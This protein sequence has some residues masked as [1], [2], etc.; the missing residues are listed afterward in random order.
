M[1]QMHGTYITHSPGTMTSVNNDIASSAKRRAI[2][3]KPKSHTTEFMRHSQTAERVLRAPLC[4]QVGL[5]VKKRFSH[6]GIYVSW[7]NG[8]DANFLWSQFTSHRARHLKNCSFAGIVSCPM[9]SLVGDT[10]AHTTN[11]DDTARE[12]KFFHLS[13]SSLRS[14]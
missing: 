14:V 5:R 7:A 13:T 6:V 3:S 8:V 4:S 10:S 11:H 12:T 9:H 1:T 2:P